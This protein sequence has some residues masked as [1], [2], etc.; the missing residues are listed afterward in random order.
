MPQKKKLPKNWGKIKI[1]NVKEF[2]KKFLAIRKRIKN[3][4]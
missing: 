2:E 3:D 4:Y 1:K